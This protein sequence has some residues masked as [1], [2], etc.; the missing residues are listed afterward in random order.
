MENFET[1]FLAEIKEVKQVKLVSLDNQF[2]I[3]LI[4]DDS[5]ILDLGKLPSDTIVEVKI[6]AVKKPKEKWEI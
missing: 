5:K 6:K 4:T 2:S 3:K 1:T